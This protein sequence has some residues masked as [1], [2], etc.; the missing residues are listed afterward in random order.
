M[1]YMIEHD[2]EPTSYQKHAHGIEDCAMVLAKRGNSVV[3][4]VE[5]GIENQ[6]RILGGTTLFSERK[7]LTGWDVARMDE[8]DE[9]VIAV[10]LSSTESHSRSTQSLVPAASWC[11]FLSTVGHS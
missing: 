4:E 6:L 3:I 5:H 1:V 9:A 11:S 7:Q 10:A 2:L 8:G